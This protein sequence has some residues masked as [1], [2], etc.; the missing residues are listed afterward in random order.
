M[1]HNLM[2]EPRK[3]ESDEP[4][5]VSCDSRYRHHRFCLRYRHPVF[6]IILCER[7]VVPGRP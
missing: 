3:E 7:R 1:V 6:P 5:D 2:Y 4:G